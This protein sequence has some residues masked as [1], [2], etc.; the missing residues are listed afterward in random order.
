MEPALWRRTAERWMVRAYQEWR[1]TVRE[2]G[3]ESS[4]ETRLAFRAGIDAMKDHLTE[5]GSCS[6]PPHAGRGGGDTY[7][8]TAI[9]ELDDGPRICGCD[10]DGA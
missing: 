7:I 4:V 3:I 6:H 1:L 10:E 2:I 9:Y 8:C 5:C